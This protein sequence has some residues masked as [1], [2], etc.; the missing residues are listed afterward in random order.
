MSNSKLIQKLNAFMVLSEDELSIL[1]NLG[2][3]GRRIPAGRDLVYQ[4]QSDKVAYILNSGWAFSY[5]LLQDGQRQILDF[6]VPGDF[7]GLRSILLN[8]SDHGIE[9]VTDIEVTELH[10]DELLEI[11]SQSP[12]LMLAVLWAAS[13]DDAMIVEHLIDVGRR[14]ATERMAHYLMELGLRLELVGMADRSGFACPLT[15]YLLADAVGLSAVHV[16]RVL[17]ELRENGLLTFR[18]GCV[19]FDDYVELSRFAQFDE[20]YLDHS[21]PRFRQSFLAGLGNWREAG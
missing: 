16:N 13:R 8:M 20:T 11:F 18:D 1:K 10:I 19:R 6:E 5:K 21:G 14:S 12:R 3:A 9:A 2:K 7:L 17:R 4:G 15:Q